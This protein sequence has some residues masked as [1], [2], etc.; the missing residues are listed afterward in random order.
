MLRS[1]D[2]SKSYGHFIN[3][4]LKIV[5]WDIKNPNKQT[6]DQDTHCFPVIDIEYCLEY[7]R[8]LPFFTFY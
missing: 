6:N 5:D 3:C 1:A 2:F 8:V 7:N 4:I